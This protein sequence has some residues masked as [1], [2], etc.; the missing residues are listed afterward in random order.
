VKDEPGRWERRADRAFT[1]VVVTISVL[2]VALMI[3][4]ALLLAF[5][6]PQ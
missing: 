4:G 3:A 5:W 2:I 6:P 1:G